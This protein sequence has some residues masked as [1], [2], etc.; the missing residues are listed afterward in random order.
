M[1]IVSHLPAAIATAHA[2]RHRTAGKLASCTS[3]VVDIVG[4]TWARWTT[5]RLRAPAPHSL[6]A[7]PGA[8]ALTARHQ[9]RSRR[10]RS[11][12]PR[13]FVATAGFILAAAPWTLVFFAP[14]SQGAQ[15]PSLASQAETSSTQ[16]NY[17]P[18]L[19]VPLG[20]AGS[21]SARTSGVVGDGASVA[22]QP[23]SD[24]S[25]VVNVGAAPPP[26][27]WLVNA[28]LRQPASAI[29][30]APLVPSAILD[31]LKSTG[32]PRLALAAYINAAASQ[33]RQSPTCGLSWQVLAGIGYIESDHAR[34]GGSAKPGWSGVANPPI[35]GPLLD[36]SSGIALIPDTDHGALDGSVTY[37]R[38]VGPMQ[39]LPSTWREYEEGASGH[40]A[41]DPQNINDATVSAARYLCASGQD[42]RTANG[43]IAAVYGYNHSFSYV[44]AVL[45]VAIRYAGGTLPGGTSAL[46]E[47]PALAQTA[48][49]LPS[50][51]PTPTVLASPTPSQMTP[52]APPSSS[53]GSSTP[54]APVYPQPPMPVSSPT[55]SVP[56]L[57]V[58]SPPQAPLPT[59]SPTDTASPTDTNSPSPT[60]SPSDTASATDSPA[61]IDP[62]PTDT[63]SDSPVPGSTLPSSESPSPSVVESTSSAPAA[64]SE[65]P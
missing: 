6:V 5:P 53:S 2:G 12:P 57:P 47:L 16:P 49:S 55:L 8:H 25:T 59:D 42:L 15:P 10:R 36:G 35:Y 13:A 61:P 39:F 9:R 50:A 32:I 1:R 11:G 65:M 37:D 19:V 56:G 64:T 40:S 44:S 41:P 21:D 24:A 34:S 58:A 52:P 28:Q 14:V 22:S 33:D 62:S 43:L 51:F 54:P 18:L 46:K 20:S 3:A 7:S 31:S 26:P 30:S 29:G 60:D 63:I 38:A 27:L 17:A 45:S 48:S 23:L 4:P